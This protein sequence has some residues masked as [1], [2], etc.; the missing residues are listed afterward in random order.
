M[1][2]SPFCPRSA[3]GHFPGARSRVCLSHLARGGRRRGGG[4]RAPVQPGGA[5]LTACVFIH[6]DSQ[7]TSHYG[8]TMRGFRGQGQDFFPSVPAALCR[9]VCAPLLRIKGDPF[10]M[11]HIL[12]P[13]QQVTFI[14]VHLQPVF[15][16][17][18]LL[19]G[20]GRGA[21]PFNGP[22]ATFISCYSVTN[23]LI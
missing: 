20:G 4:Q 13:P 3:G 19:R 23:W 10:S 21:G 12:I 6:T 22:T 1:P 15:I 16:K 14:K 2:T 18:R 5:G 11:H 17:Y 9:C 8:G 7:L